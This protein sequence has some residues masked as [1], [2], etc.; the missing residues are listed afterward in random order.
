MISLVKIVPRALVEKGV[1]GNCVEV[2]NE[3]KTGCSTDITVLTEFSLE[4]VSGVGSVIT[5]CG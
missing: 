3:T 5:L 4:L 2:D 1:D